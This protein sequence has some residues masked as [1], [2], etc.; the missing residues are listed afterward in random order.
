MQ[1][2]PGASAPERVT[3]WSFE[4]SVN[5]VR[6]SLTNRGRRVSI[7]RPFWK[8]R[9]FQI[10]ACAVGLGVVVAVIW[11]IM[12]E[13]EAQSTPKVWPWERWCKQKSLG[14]DEKQSG[15]IVSARSDLPAE[16]PKHTEYEVFYAIH[17]LSMGGAL[18]SMFNLAHSSILLQEKGKASGEGLNM[19]IEYGAVDFS[20]GVISPVI[21]TNGSLSWKDDAVVQWYPWANRWKWINESKVTLLGT[22][23]GEGLN[24]WFQQIPGYA[25]RNAGYQVWS[26]Y[27]GEDVTTAHMYRK[28]SICHDFTEWGMVKL[29][30][31]KYAKFRHEEPLCRNYFALQTKKMPKFVEDDLKP[32]MINFYENLRSVAQSTFQNFTEF[33]EFLRSHFERHGHN[34]YIHE[35]S[36][37]IN[38]PVDHRYYKVELAPPFISPTIYRKIKVKWQTNSGSE[39]ECSSLMLRSDSSSL[40]V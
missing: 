29:H 7:K 1:K 20:P 27:S 19:V 18:V 24:K 23:T 22:V 11:W 25:Q 40:V 38:K 39:G 32:D 34:A 26:A 13:S 3:G 8:T 6:N 35:K 15:C 28:S 9:A 37:F 2:N 31:T 16:L 33:T 17:L 36:T 5:N 4:T 21:H 12:R 30:E 14:T 10:I